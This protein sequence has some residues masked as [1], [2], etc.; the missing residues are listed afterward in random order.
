MPR[1]ISMPLIEVEV[2][3]RRPCSRN[4]LAIDVNGRGARQNPLSASIFGWQIFP[5][6][7]FWLEDTVK[8]VKKGRRI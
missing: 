8:T 1:L 3:D 7:S 5:N 6:G 2:E 4:A